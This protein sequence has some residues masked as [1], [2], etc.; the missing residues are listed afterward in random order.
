MRAASGW[1]IAAVA[2][3]SGRR[4]EFL[5]TP[6]TLCPAKKETSKTGNGKRGNGK[7]KTDLL[8]G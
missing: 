3:V 4:K 6:E 5:E 1:K 7:R 8:G 2:L